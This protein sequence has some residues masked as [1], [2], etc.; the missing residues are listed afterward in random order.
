MTQV[1]VLIIAA[2]PEELDAARTAAIAATPGA[3]GIQGWAI[4]DRGGSVPYLF[5]QYL[6]SGGRRLSVALA[7]PTRIG[8]RTTGPVATTLTDRLNPT[9]LAMCGVCAGNPAEAAPGD[10]VVAD[11]T[12][13]YDEGRHTTASFEGDHR[14]YPLD[15]RWVRAAQEFDPTGLP[16]YGAATDAEAMIWL[17]ERLYVGQE[18]RSHP[19]RIRY[20]PRGTW[21]PRLERM[22]AAGLIIRD[23]DRWALA[24]PGESLIKE[25]LYD[26]VDGP[27]RL[28]FAVLVGPMASGAAVV[29]DG[30]IWNRLK[31]MGVRRVT[32]LEMEAATV[33]TVAHERQVPHW[34]IAKGVMDPADPT[35]DD[36]YKGFAARASAEVLFALLNRL[37]PNDRTP[38]STTRA[39][40][41]DTNAISGDGVR[42]R[43]TADL[44]IV[45]TAGTVSMSGLLP[46]PTDRH[47]DIGA[48]LARHAR[49]RQPQI[50]VLIGPT[51]SGKSALLRHLVPHYRKLGDRVQ[52]IDLSLV[53]WKR[54][55]L[56]G[57]HLDVAL[58]DHI[59]RITDS[60]HFQAAF[61]IIDRVLPAM[62]SSGMSRLILTVGLDWRDS[63]REIYRMTPEAL[64][65]TSTPGVRFN[66]HLLR[67]YTNAEFETLCATVGLDPDELTDL[68]LRR[69]GVLAM[70]RRA[71]DDTA[72]MTG[73][74]LREVL[75]R[76]W[77][78]TGVDIEA[79]G[80]RRAMWTL[81]GRHTLLD[82]PFALGLQDLYSSLDSRFSRE[83]LRAQVGGPFRW[84]DD[85]VQSESPAWAD[86][87][88][89]NTLQAAIAGRQVDT[90][91]HPVRS[92]VL[93]ALIGLNDHRELSAQVERS[94][95]SLRGTDFTTMG[96]LGPTVGT[97]FAQLTTDAELILQELSLQGPDHSQLRSVDRGVAQV[98][99]QALLGAMS[100]GVE[101]LFIQLGGLSPDTASAYR[102]GYQCWLTARRWA[103]S[104]PLRASAEDAVLKNL[105]GD[106][107]WRYEDILDVSVT[108]ATTKLMD[109]RAERFLAVLSRLPDRAAEFLADIWDGI[110]DGAWDQIDA[111]SQG[112]VASLCLPSEMSTV[113]KAQS[114]RLQRAH[115]GRQDTRG[116]RLVNCDL[117]LADFRS[118]RNVELID[119]T[120]SNWWAAILPPPARYHL[121]RDCSSSAFLEWCEAPPWRNPYYTAAWPTPLD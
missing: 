67:P 7:R 81:M 42:Q 112:F 95:R 105:P 89:A 2:L 29:R 35:K 11:V 38:A 66:A 55:L 18:P 117:L 22:E 30:M 119:F 41:T 54:A 9:C 101:Q 40:L 60:E 91:K 12:Y 83:V 47:R 48:T 39:L 73:T 99:E 103:G 96:Y 51:D 75:V 31:A 76:R 32:A 63:F 13:E 100:A 94:L 118:C 50:D 15:A 121:S 49:E 78:E 80:A 90:I 92:S 44:V 37:F 8:G 10:V 72:R 93:R 113:L 25:T 24:A 106:G 61:T 104:L 79:R 23:Q 21:R 56:T 1:D 87:A 46:V 88:A 86:V 77:I 20:F 70:A 107:S 115:L 69:P 14:Q 3:P 26:D 65:H 64:L 71:G 114:C 110:N 108:G 5:G 120:G 59:D 68:S 57:G 62:F 74:R 82:E 6:T 102:G 27:E 17:L 98:V 28:P 111:S 85:Q 45:H 36:R 4:R 53:A 109:G 97:L 19:A 43:E 16:S 84:E 116:W 34:L 33:A 52:L 58:I